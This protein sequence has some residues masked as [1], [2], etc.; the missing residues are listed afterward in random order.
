M[1][2]DFGPGYRVYLTQEGDRLVVLLIGGD[3]SSQEADIERAKHLA[4][5]WRRANGR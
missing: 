2:F 4:M 3:K 1:R 5:E